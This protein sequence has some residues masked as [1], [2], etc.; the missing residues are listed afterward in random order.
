MKR[1]L[2][3]S[4][5]IF[6]FIFIVPSAYAADAVNLS[7]GKPYT[8]TRV[9]S[10]FF[11]DTGN[12]ELTDGIFGTKSYLADSAWTGTSYLETES[13]M[14]YDEWPL[15]TTVIDLQSVCSITEVY[16]NFVRDMNLGVGFPAS[17]TVYAST[18]NEN[19]MKLC[20][21]H[22]IFDHIPDG[23]YRFGW[24]I[25][26]VDSNHTVDLVGNSPIKA[27]YIRYDFETRSDMHLIDEIT[28]MG[29]EGITDDAVTPHS[30]RKLENDEIMR[31]G[32][33]TGF[34]NDLVLINYTP[35]KFWTTETLKPYL[36]YI[37]P[38]GNSLD[39]LYDT[40]CFVANESENG[41]VFD[42]EN[43]VVTINDWKWYLD[44]T[45][46]G[47]NSEVY[48]LNETAKQASID[49]N[50][51]DYKVNLVVMMPYP[52]KN[53]TNFGV[54]N[55][56]SL[57]LSVEEDWKYAVEWYLNEVINRIENGNYHYIDF[58]GF[59]WINEY[60]NEI[61]RIIYTNEL[62]H[63]LE[64]KSYWIPYFHSRGYLWQETLGFDAITLQPNHFFSDSYG[65]TLG[66]GGTKVVETVAK[67]GAYANIG[68]EMEFD[69]RLD[70][71][72]DAYNRFLDYLNTAANMGYQGTGYYRNWYEA[73]G[74][75][76]GLAYSKAPEIR[77]LY[78]NVYELMKGCYEPREY[79]SGLNENLLSGKSYTH[80][81]TK[82]YADRSDDT[83]CIYLT[84]NEVAGNFYGN[85][86]FGTENQDATVEFDLSAS[87]ISLREIHV[88][89]FK[90]KSA[91][92]NLPKNLKI[93]AK[94][95][96][97]GDWELIYDGA[98]PDANRAVF[99]SYADIKAYGLKFEFTRDGGFLFIKEIMAY[100]NK[101]AVK[102]DAELISRDWL[103]GDVNSDGFINNADVIQINRKNANLSS[104]F[105]IEEGREHR[106]KAADVT[107]DNF[108]N[109]ADVFQINRKTANMSSLLDDL[110]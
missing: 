87:P 88:V 57:N 39:T 86:Y 74:G 110:Q 50:N 101:N 96:K 49:L 15:Y 26:D 90:D 34:V 68:V 29:Y 75:I 20:Y 14:V 4:A 16:G 27:R 22:S 107:R 67:L 54:L 108:I 93:H 103:F 48:I 38:D 76:Y 1:L 18:D 95:S 2:L 81:A 63:S 37:D 104:I 94:S 45:F 80:N 91:G 44:R 84:D 42:I 40:V 35:N 6:A 100:E 25:D 31:S 12:I 51:P 47:E 97:A 72:K 32:E 24:H 106:L 105:D 59:Y 53:A 36:T 41:R 8:N 9:V 92:V 52:P 102:S 10:Q 56:K 69:L 70:I 60:P 78:D 58:K 11:P 5:I 64:L 98:F 21:T 19:W 73:G 99:T 13:G 7:V 79:I 17:V 62:I 3:L 66:A 82:W 85:A 43:N 28:V 23:I 77:T 89:A 83:N 55:G 61:S 71:D 30:T 33:A 65:N 109:N 46:S